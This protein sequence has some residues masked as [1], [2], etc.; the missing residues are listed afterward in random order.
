MT[1]KIGIAG[2]MGRMGQALVA[3]V[4]A[5]PEAA[6][7]GGLEYPGHPSLGANIRD[8]AH[9]DTGLVVTS[10]QDAL[11]AASD[12]VIDFTTPDALAGHLAAARAHGAALL[13]GTTGLTAAHHQ[14]LDEAGHHL[15]LLQCA[16]ASLGVNLLL[17][18]V[19]QTA[20]R[21]GAEWDIEIVEMHHRHK[22]DAPSGTALALGAAAAAGRGID[23]GRHQ[24]LS[25]EGITGARPAGSIGFATLRGGNVAGDHS[26]IFAADDERIE[27]T[28]KAGDRR[29][30][31]HGAVTAALWLA[32]QAPGRY[33]MADMLGLSAKN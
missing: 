11:F 7:A 27:L 15:P 2:V 3:A 18:L 1:I 19:E 16:N 4:A 22:V 5:K 20:A 28:H 23:L 33:T 30:F 31:A 29:I 21:L 24:V 10:D 12:V 13:I 6:L 26:V 25:R 32:G 9:Q 8:G 17:G 14:A